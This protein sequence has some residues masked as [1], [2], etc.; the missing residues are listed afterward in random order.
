MRALLAMLLLP[1]T[2]PAQTLFPELVATLPSV[3][4][5]VS[6][7]IVVDGKPW[8][9][10]DS[11]NPNALYQL[12]RATGA[13]LRTVT[14]ANVT[15]TDWEALATD[16][17]HVHVGD[18][19]NNAGART[20]LRIVR[21]PVEALLDEEVTEVYAE[22]T[23]FT[24][25]DQADFTPAW[26]ANNWD[27]E[28]FIVL[29]DTAFLFT[30][31]WLDQRTHLYALP[32]APGE[33]LAVRRDTLETEGLVTGASLR[34][35]GAAIALIGHD[36]QGHPLLWTLDH[37]SGHALFGGDRA[38]WVLQ[39]PEAQVEAVAWVAQDSV[40]F[41][42]EASPT[43]PAELWKLHVDM[44]MDLG[45]TMAVRGVRAWPNP[46]REYFALQLPPGGHE[47]RLLHVD[48]REVLRTRASADGSV[49]VDDVAPGHYLWEVVLAHGT[50]RR[51]HVVIVR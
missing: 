37:F 32:L 41:A 27:C 42:H 31:N 38:R 24:Y 46:C 45:P 21:F 12:D 6:D 29:Q 43:T 15:N 50:L 47:V 26:D 17:V 39:M 44:G 25:A 7:M 20:D 2:L 23:T 11:G 33:Q 34:T 14:V 10:L 8:V 28:A 30:K 35:D 36:M 4:D 40:L 13:I 3:L 49:R 51:G 16:G 22:T 5:E 19:G 18:I 9:V 48:G 1:G